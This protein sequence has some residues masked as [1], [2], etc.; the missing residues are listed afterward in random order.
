MS[1]TSVPEKTRLI[2]WGMAGGRCEYRGCNRP[3]YCDDLSKAQFNS[4]YVAHI[5][6]DKPKGPRGSAK[7][8][9]RLKDQLSNLMLLCD[10][11]HRLIDKEEVKGHPVRLLRQMKEHHEARIE[12][13]TGISEDLK[14]LMVVYRANVGAHVPVMSYDVLL[15][16]MP[17]RYPAEGRT[18]ELGLVNSP[19]RDTNAEFWRMELAALEKNFDR[20]IRPRLEAKEINHL[21]VFAL[22]PQPLLVILGVLFGDITD[23]DIRQPI[24]N[25][26]TWNWLTLDSTPDYRVGKP[27]GKRSKVAL[28]ISLSGT[29]VNDRIC[30]VLGEDCSVYTLTVDNPFNDFLRSEAQL[31]R[32]GEIIRRLL[33][34]IKAEYGGNTPLHVFP[35]M[36]VSASI[37]LG[38]RWMPKADMSL[39]IYD[40]NTAIGGFV[41]SLTI[42]NEVEDGR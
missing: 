5:V 15:P 24:R 26:K 28:N 23:V 21:T 31:I 30:A 7:D 36:P 42:R 6:A 19:Q 1:F 11:H 38:R 22:A 8:S 34:E 2:L 32:F 18:V 17:P 13:V 33:D 14:S 41:E 9:P 27:I 25:P 39:I 29:V 3:L 10:V 37:E 4:A 12:T 20:K 16:F 35:A 40:Q